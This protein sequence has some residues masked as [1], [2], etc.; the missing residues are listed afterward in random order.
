M[1]KL[2]IITLFL[3]LTLS[4][5]SQDATEGEFSRDLT[6]ERE[7]DP[8][9]ANAKKISP[10]PQKEVIE[11]EQPEIT[12]TTWSKVEKTDKS[13]AVQDAAEYEAE[14][15]YD[16]KKGM[17][18]AG[19][20]FYWQVIGEFYYPI[21]KM[22]NHLLDVSVKHNSAWGNIELEDGTKP[23]GMNH[24]TDLGLNYETNFKNSKLETGISYAYNGYDYYGLSN[25]PND[26]MKDTIGS[27]NDVDFNL[28]YYSTN[29]KSDFQYRAHL[30]YKYFS[31]NFNISAHMIKFGAELAGKLSTGELGAE[32]DFDIDV[33]NMDNKSAD[34]HPHTAGLFK[35]KPFYKLHG[36][37]WAVNLGA[38]LF[39]DMNKEA[40]RPV[41]GS[42]DIDANFAVVPDLFYMYAGIGG[43]FK[44]NY[45]YDIVRENPYIN[46]DLEVSPTYT[47]FDVN[48]GL[49]VRIM[50]GLLFNVGMDYSIILDQYYFVNNVVT[51]KVII[52]D[53]L[54]Y[55]NTF[56]VVTENTTHKLAVEAGLYFDYVKGLD[57]G[58]TAGYNYWG[59]TDNQY[60]WQKPSWKV[61]FT[62][63]YEFLE[64]W[65]V[66]LSYKFLGDRKALVQ[67]D[68]VKMNDVHD[69]DVWASY[70]AL[71]W[72]TVF[73]KGK[74]LANQKSDT[75][76]GYRNFGI[77]GLVGVTM[78]F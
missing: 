44:P 37:D 22:D 52:S 45:Y 65:E 54:G 75:Y 36:E 46:P 59:V 69:L 27:N 53:T 41:T 51:D 14:R 33:L 3:G 23:R 24:I 77:N 47:P 39:V 68:I 34:S 40:K 6:V 26:I 10:T 29:H 31:R 76:Y 56:N 62:G 21:L 9:V 13:V 78:L 72:L 49:R 32:V 43:D 58:V 71:D 61:E 57:L 60:A 35:L 4:V 66:G 55:T 73:L 70:K 8:T 50:E 2:T 64:K 5:Y 15:T 28:K 48:I 18:K 19:L 11:V 30:G 20:G 42:A 17:F 1:R 16:E 38:N 12:Y 74:N 7:Y 63:T 67:G 25:I